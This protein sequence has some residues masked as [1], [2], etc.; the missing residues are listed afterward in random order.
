MSFLSG[1]HK[2]LEDFK[3]KIESLKLFI[4]TLADTGNNFILFFLTAMFDRVVLV[5]VFGTVHKHCMP[6]S[7]D[8]CEYVSSVCTAKHRGT[9]RYRQVALN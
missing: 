1:Q 8:S 2:T 6:H 9:L 5:F 7:I 4:S 3:S